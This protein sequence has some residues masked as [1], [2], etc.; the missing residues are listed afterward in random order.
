[1]NMRFR[2][3]VRWSLLPGAC[4][5]VDVSLFAQTTQTIGAGSAVTRIDRAASFDAISQDGI[6]LS[7]YT[8]AGLFIGV[9]GDSLT[10]FDPFHG[11]GGPSPTFEYPDF[12]SP[13]WVTIYATDAKPIYAVEFMYGNGW[14]TG[15][16]TWPWGNDQAV[17]EWE[18]WKGG[19]MVSSGTVGDTQTLS[20]GTIVGFYDPSGFD[21]LHLR[22][23]VDTSVDLQAL[24]LD[25]LNVQL[26]DPAA[27]WTNYGIGWT[28]TLGVPTLMPDA[29]PV[30]G[31]TVTIT[32]SNSLGAA[33]DGLIVLGFTEANVPTSKDGVILVQP[34][35]FLLDVVPAAGLDMVGTLPPYDPALCGLEIDV[36]GIELDPGASKGLS[37]SPGLKLILGV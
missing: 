6:A 23:R 34:L 8:E 9:D 26:W 2:N 25:S 27:S 31:T 15:D 35:Y 13:G 36:Q 1:M 18:T 19:T 10:G 17:L 32:L 22:C 37:F 7:D 29:N 3:V 12:G 33:T 28:G 30:L 20:M 5:A 14:T 16:P 11:V 24:A 4:L 21:E